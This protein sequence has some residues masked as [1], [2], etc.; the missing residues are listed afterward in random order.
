MCGSNAD[1]ECVLDED[2]EGP[3]YPLQRIDL[4]MK[5]EHNVKKIIKAVL[6]R[7]STIFVC[8]MRN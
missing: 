1:N 2:E 7:Y 6:G 8:I 3:L 5:Q 4:V